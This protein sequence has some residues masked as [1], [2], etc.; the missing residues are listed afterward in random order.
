[1]SLI[2][3]NNPN[4]HI[5]VGSE[6]INSLNKVTELN[7]NYYD[8]LNYYAENVDTINKIDVG[9]LK[10]LMANKGIKP[11]VSSMKKHQ[12]VD[13]LQKRI[14]NTLKIVDDEEDLTDGINKLKDG[15]YVA[16]I[17]GLPLVITNN[18]NNAILARDIAAYYIDG[19][20][21]RCQHKTHKLGVEKLRSWGKIHPLTLKLLQLIKEDESDYEFID[22]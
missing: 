8:S 7:L 1:M 11:A 9:I 4:E 17:D 16:E 19:N 21:L 6:E 3:I 12:I 2:V 13:L 10:K 22:E 14:V 5:N 18:R 20:N 15:R